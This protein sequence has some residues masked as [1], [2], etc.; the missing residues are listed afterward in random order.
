MAGNEMSAVNDIAE[1]LA[2]VRERIARACARAHRE[3]PSSDV[4]ACTEI[5]RER[6]TAASEGKPPVRLVLASKTQPP[7]AIAA[8]YA[9]GAR[10]F[11]ENYVQEAIAK[12]AALSHLTD[13]RWHLIGHLQ[14][15]KARAAVDHFDL[16]HTLD[17]PRLANAL[18]RIR[19]TPA[20]PVLI[21]V[22]LGGEASKSGV[23]PDAVAPLLDS[24]RT[25]VD[26]RGLMTIPPP[27]SDPRDSRRWFARLRELRDRLAIATGLA[28]QELSMG[29]TEDFEYA[30]EEGAT[31]VR[32]GRAVFGERLR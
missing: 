17:S 5:G 18:A 10:D 30:I 4:S 25:T 6:L 28:L 31:I 20:V 3:A 29:M 27:A 15:N 8:A 19:P 21:E 14:S 13:A 22:N 16:I 12:R 9:A 7:E 11:G 32:V 23:P 24:V 1:R 26:V 2:E